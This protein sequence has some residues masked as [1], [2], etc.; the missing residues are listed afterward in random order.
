MRY[1]VYAILHLIILVFYIGRPLIPFIQYAAFKDYIASNLCVNKDIPKSCCKGKC[2]LEKQLKKS[3]ENND[4]EEKGTNKKITNKE[5][6]E[7]LTAHISIPK[8]TAITVHQFI[9]AETIIFSQAVSTIF[10]P[11]KA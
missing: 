8:A 4:T 5:V 1:R 6:K 10:V 7:F 2:Y 11:P 3:T 9:N